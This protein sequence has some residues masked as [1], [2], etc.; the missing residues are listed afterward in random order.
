MSDVFPKQYYAATCMIHT[1][2]HTH[3]SLSDVKE[4]NAVERV[5]WRRLFPRSRV[6]KY[7]Q[8]LNCAGMVPFN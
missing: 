3:N 4:A 2:T 6:S 7:V 5:P 8:E 1:H